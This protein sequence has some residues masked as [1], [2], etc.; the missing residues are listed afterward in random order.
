MLAGGKNR[1]RIKRA[2]KEAF[3]RVLDQ[4]SMLSDQHRRETECWSAMK[5]LLLST[6]NWKRAPRGKP[7]R[8]F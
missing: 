5:T 6:G 7:R 4:L 3:L 2:D 8:S 1:I